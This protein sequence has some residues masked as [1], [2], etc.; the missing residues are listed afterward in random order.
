M[1][2]SL[3]FVVG[4]GDKASE[5]SVSQSSA[6]VSES[7]HGHPHDSEGDDNHRHKVEGHTHGAGPH[8]GTIADWGGG[9]Y[10]V[11]FTVDHDKKEATVYVLG[12]D[13]KTPTPIATESVLLTIKDPQLQVDLRPVPLE[14]ESA[15]MSSRFAGTHDGLATVKEYQGTMSAL[16]DGTPYAGDFSEVAHDHHGE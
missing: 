5:Q 15:G 1:L 2:L 11:E 8:N 9:T 16:V 13:E 10:H 14:G 12:S 6:G 7:D 4:C 3:S